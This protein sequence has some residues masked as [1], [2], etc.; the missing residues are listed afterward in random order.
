MIMQT[1]HKTMKLI[2]TLGIIGVASLLYSRAPQNTDTNQITSLMASLSDQT[3]APADVLDP[4]LNSADRA[5]NLKRFGSANYQLN[6]VPTER[7]YHITAGSAVIPVHVLFKSAD[8][9]ELERDATIT[10][11]KRKGIW[12][13]ANF[14]FL[15]WPTFL[16]VILFACLLVGVGYAVTVLVLRNRLIKRGPL[17]TDILK[18]FIPFFW[19]DLF[20]RTR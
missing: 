15:R 12:Y 16:I 5:T 7:V 4:E 13:F 10:F 18:I 8:G 14:D 9:S 17:G 20:R 2:A 3:K 1:R 19:P 11:V 6:L